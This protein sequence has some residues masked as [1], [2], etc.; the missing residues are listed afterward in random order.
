MPL[1]LFGCWRRPSTPAA[2]AATSTNADFAGC[3]GL[4]LL[5]ATFTIGLLFCCSLW[6]INWLLVVSYEQV[7]AISSVAIGC[8]RIIAASPVYANASSVLPAPLPSCRQHRLYPAT[9]PAVLSCM[10]APLCERFDA[11]PIKWNVS[12]YQAD[13]HLSLPNEHG[14]AVRTCRLANDTKSLEDASRWFHCTYDPLITTVSPPWVPPP[15]PSPKKQGVMYQQLSPSCR[16]AQWN[17]PLPALLEPHRCMRVTVR[18]GVDSATETRRVSQTCQ[19]GGTC[20]QL[21]VSV[22]AAPRRLSP[23]DGSSCEVLLWLQHTAL[24][25]IAMSFLLISYELY[26]GYRMRMCVPTPT[27]CV[28]CTHPLGSAES[29]RL[30][31][32]HTFHRIC[33]QQ[34]AARARSCPLCRHMF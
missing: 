22:L 15:P 20:A 30:L 7:L 34:W 33:L 1:I 27:D 23:A 3:V 29:K 2:L 5:I 8:N 17:R 21:N 16:C 11:C 19:I 6:A 31:C 14:L 13:P 24:A 10:P 18:M 28:I 9:S 26:I 12:A 25:I 4:L 32:Q